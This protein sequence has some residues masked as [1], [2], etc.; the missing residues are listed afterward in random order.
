[1]PNAQTE[2]DRQRFRAVMGHFATGVAVVTGLG[3]DGAVGMTT[4]ALCSVSLDPLLVLVCFDN[5]AR[6]LPVVQASGRFGVN[7]L[8]ARQHDLSGQFASKLP[9]DRKFDAVEYTLEREVPVLEGVLA[10]L[11]CELRELLPGGDHTI[12]VGEV[13][14]MGHADGEPLVWYR[15]AYTSVAGSGR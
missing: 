9:L 6:T 2:A 11:V 7:V 3:P 10:W 12:G 8:G 4:N 13:L 5:T 15:G 1:M 14:A